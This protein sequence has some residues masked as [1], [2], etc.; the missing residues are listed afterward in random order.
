MNIFAVGIFFCKYSINPFCADQYETEDS[1]AQ[2]SALLKSSALVLLPLYAIGYLFTVPV[3]DI[4]ASIPVFPP[5]KVKLYGLENI[6]ESPF[7]PST[8]S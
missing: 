7:S 2:F 5:S 4:V 8:S 6:T 3:S 1:Y